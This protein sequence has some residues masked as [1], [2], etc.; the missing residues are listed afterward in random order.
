MLVKLPMWLTTRW[1]AS[2]R[3]QATVNAA[4]APLENPAMARATG[5]FVSVYFFRTS[6]SISSTMCFANASPR[7]SHS[8]PRLF[9]FMV[10]SVAG[11]SAPL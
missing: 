9:G 11:Y 5:S 3:S 4:T 6:G 2:G 10:P 7:E 1:K 8:T